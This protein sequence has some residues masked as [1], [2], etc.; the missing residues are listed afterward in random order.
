[1]NK[2]MKFAVA[3]IVVAFAPLVSATSISVP[4]IQ[5][6]SLSGAGGTSASI[7]SGSG[8]LYNASGSA[9][10][11]TASTISTVPVGS[12]G[13]LSTQTTKVSTSGKASGGTQ[14][15][16]TSTSLGFGVAAGAPA[17]APGG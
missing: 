5:A 10:V 2:S 16:G 1:M 14:G 13:P 11:S 9:K 8:S 7:G 6:V 12:S 4:P 3:T 17:P 15:S